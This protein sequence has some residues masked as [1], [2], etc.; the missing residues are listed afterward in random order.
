M[1]DR[2][3]MITRWIS[4]LVVTEEKLRNRAKRFVK[5][6]KVAE[7]LRQ[8]HNYHTLMAVLS[9]LNDGPVYR[10]KFTK[11]E[12]PVKYQQVKDKILYIVIPCVFILPDMENPYILN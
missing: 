12:I 6:I 9:G 5:F 3:N 4:T 11:D 7:A 1:I 2:F 8:M 10:L